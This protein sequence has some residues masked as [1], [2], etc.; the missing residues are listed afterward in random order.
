MTAELLVAVVGAGPAGMY[1]ADALIYQSRVPVR[2]DVFDRLPTPFGL[3]RYGVAPDHLK[4]KLLARALQRTLDDERVRFF[5]NVHVGTDV[6]VEE[7]RAGYHAVAYTFGASSDRQLGIP[8]ETLTGS[9]SATDFVAWYSGH[10]DVAETRFDLQGVRAAAVVGLGN[11]AVDVSRVLV[12][13]VAE[14][15]KTDIPDPVLDRLA[16]SGVSD[17]HLLGRRGPVQAK[18]T[19]KELKELGELDG[20]DVVVDRSQVELTSQDRAEL[21]ADPTLRRNLDILT[22]WSERG[23][24]GAPRR[25]HLHFWARPVEVLG[26]AGRVSA[27]RVEPTRLEGDRVVPNGA[28]YDLPVQLL[29]RSV[30]YRG[31][32]LRGVPLHDDS[33]TVPHTSGRVHR[34]GQVSAGEYVAGWIG[35][36]PVGVLGTNRSDAEG[37]VDRLLEDAPALLERELSQPLDALLVQRA[38][39]SVDCDGWSAIDAAEVA[40]GQEL[41]RP[42]TKLATWDELLGAAAMQG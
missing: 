5:G 8:G 10:P 18:F 9:S 11:V 14:L 32:Q 33:Y 39:T 35:R 25:L 41:G 27:V 36:G 28:P 30:G 20:V 1:V 6:S 22:E 31:V 34:D 37:V 12:K 21:A 13:S 40:R 24:T 16:R 7:L 3:L 15:R 17:V 38:I 4:M 42:R 23:L 2:V 19:S 29:L 26:A